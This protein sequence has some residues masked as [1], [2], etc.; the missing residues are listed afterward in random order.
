MEL[1]SCVGSLLLRKF[2]IA[3]LPS[4]GY[5]VPVSLDLFVLLGRRGMSLADFLVCS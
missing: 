3:L 2:L 1:I 5:S 4:D